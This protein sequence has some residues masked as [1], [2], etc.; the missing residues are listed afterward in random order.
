MNLAHLIPLLILLVGCSAVVSEDYVANEANDAGITTSLDQFESSDDM[1]LDEDQAVQDEDQAVEFEDQPFP[2]DFG[3][4]PTADFEVTVDMDVVDTDDPPSNEIPIREVMGLPVI[5][6]FSGAPPERVERLIRQALNG[7]GLGETDG[8]NERDRIFVGLRYMVWIDETGFYGKMNGL[9]LLNGSVQNLEFVNVD[10]DRPVNTLA[11]GE[12]G[13]GVWPSGYM[14]AEHIEVPNR[15]PDDD[16]DPQCA[17]F[18]SFCSQYSHAEAALF[19]NANIPTWRACNEG[20]PTW[21]SHFQPYLVERT[22]Q[23]IRL[24]YEGPLTKRGDFGGSTNG[25][26]CHQ[27]W[28]FED[29]F[30]R[31]VNLRVG[32]DLFVDDHRI[33]RL[34]QIDNPAG[35][36]TFGGDTSFIGGFVLTSWPNPH[37]LKQL[38]RRVRVEEHE[39]QVNW[40]GVRTPILPN[41]WTTL[42]ETIPDHDVVLG[43]AGQPVTLSPAARLMNGRTFTL[44]NHGEDTRD[45]GFCLCIVHGAIEMGG[46]LLSLPVPGGQLSHLAIRRLNLVVD[47]T[48]ARVW[49]Y[50]AET[51]LQHS[52]GRIDG[53]GW[54]ASTDQDEPGMLSFGPYSRDWGEGGRRALFRMMV[55]VV[56]SGEEHVVTLDIY[57]VE[58]NQ[59][60]AEVDIS[61]SAFNR[62]F[63]YQEFE[64]LFNT[65]GRDQ[66]P[67]EAR[68]YWHDH[69]YVRLDRIVIDE[70]Y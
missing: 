47:E 12:R 66:R 62:A 50:E 2:R 20:S 14:G 68:V 6:D 37:P 32:Y 55:D 28:M 8:P 25:T 9:W 4:E 31:R 48:P 22:A 43:Q 19:T 17:V 52:I 5:H 54:S 1:S 46:G 56:T 24:M 3:E 16:D 65:A 49:R 30:R 23:G 18:P 13:D 36:P 53:D 34:M 10:G 39:V 58:A 69:S 29:G 61:R 42:P 33:D 41:Q 7:L 59:I 35:N 15:I 60:L 57:D 26:N 27:D 51:D 64:L 11:V 38:N 63:E 21:D 67:L 45:S 44:S 40:Q 70:L